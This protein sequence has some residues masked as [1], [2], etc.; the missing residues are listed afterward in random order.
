MLVLMGVL[1]DNKYMTILRDL[2]ITDENL[3]EQMK[4]DIESD[5]KCRNIPFTKDE[6]YRAK[7]TFKGKICIKHDVE[8][9]VSDEE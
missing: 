6:Q 4:E 7:I 5:L 3:Y 9:A 1:G 2:Y 8:P